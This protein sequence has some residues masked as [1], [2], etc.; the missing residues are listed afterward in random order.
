MV[1]PSNLFWIH[2]CFYHVE[3][4]K[5]S[6]R[7]P[8]IFFATHYIIICWFFQAIIKWIQPWSIMNGKFLPISKRKPPFW[9]FYFW[10]S[11]DSYFVNFGFRLRVVFGVVMGG[12]LTRTWM[13]TE[14]LTDGATKKLTASFRPDAP[15]KYFICTKV[16]FRSFLV[17]FWL[18]YLRRSF[19]KIFSRLVFFLLAYYLSKIMYL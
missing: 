9:A 10:F 1:T 17:N 18:F 7:I 14:W 8:A 19:K 16:I 3:N 5:F 15:S 13:T 2:L 6:I 11:L 12:Q 4:W